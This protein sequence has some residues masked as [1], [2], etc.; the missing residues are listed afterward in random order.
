MQSG[1]QRIAAASRVSPPCVLLL[2]LLLLLYK[3]LVRETADATWN[4]EPDAKTAS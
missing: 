1:S 2:L 4:W 3:N